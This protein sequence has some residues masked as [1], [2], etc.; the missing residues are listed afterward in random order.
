M[1]SHNGMEMQ[2]AVCRTLL[3]RCLAASG[4]FS[5]SYVLGAAVMFF[6][7]PSAEFLNKAFV[8]AHAWNDRRGFVGPAVVAVEP[9]VRVSN[10]LKQAFDGLTL[11]MVASRQSTANCQALLTDMRGTVLHRWQIAFSQVWPNP[12]HLRGRGNDSEMC[13][14][15]GHLYPNGDLLVVFHGMDQILQ[16][17]GLVKLDK[18]SNIVWKYAARIHHDVDVGDDGTVYAIK[19]EIVDELPSDLKKTPTPCLV[20]YLVMLSPDGEEL[21]APISILEAFRKS[22]FAIHLTGLDPKK[23]DFPRGAPADRF[24]TAPYADILHANCVDVLSQEMAAQFPMFKPGQVLISVRELDTMAVLDTDSESIVWAARGPW[25]GQHDP[26]FLDNGHLLLFDNYGAVIQS[27]VLEYDPQTQAVTWSYSAPFLSKTRGMSQR[28]PNGNT[29]VV[30]SE[31]GKIVEVNPGNDIV[32]T[33]SYNGFVHLGRR[34]A[35]DQLPFLK[36][37]TQV[38]P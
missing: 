24:A 17:H 10:D 36:V 34:F 6:N 7:L 30:D 2:K 14:F 12:P 23:H 13:F 26:Q 20:D 35:L 4:I 19:Q 5:F 16:G 18:D 22:P 37:D 31:G 38:R 28:L 15:A 21:K 1:T 32:W 11:Q 9:V 8:G 27:R 29:L 33:C 3:R 25:R